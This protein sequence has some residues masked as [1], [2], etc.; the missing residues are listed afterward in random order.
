MVWKTYALAETQRGLVLRDG[1]VVEWLEPGRHRRLDP[2]N[3]LSL[4]I[5]EVGQ[6][7]IV[8]STARRLERLHPEMLKGRAVIIR[9][10]AH[11]LAL[12]SVDGM[13]YAVVPHT[14]MKALWTLMHDVEVEIIDLNTADSI[15]PK[16]AARWAPLAGRAIV[17][18]VIAEGETGLLMVDDQ[19]V[20]RLPPG[21][22][23]YWAADRT[24]RIVPQDL[25]PRT[26][27]V[28]A[29]E[30]LTEDRVTLRINVTAMLQVTDPERLVQRVAALDP[31]V[32]RQIQLAV[33]DAVGGRTLDA[34]LKARQEV[35]AGLTRT[36]ADRLG[37]IGVEIADVRIKDVILPGDMREM[38][39]RVVEAEKAAEANLI[40][41][42]EETAAT[43]ALL[44][45]ARLMENHPALMRLKELEALER[46]T[47]KVGRI[48]VHQTAQGAGLPAL[49][50]T[51]MG[52]RKEDDRPAL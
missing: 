8:T 41:R 24:V 1:C 44:N 29:Q 51:L 3:R 20:R 7:I 22:H 37:D 36:V 2:A 15:A 38:L 11:E 5:L 25:R 12:V 27:E 9:P 33:R 18:A 32:H 46:L 17:Q 21:R 10:A 49:I 42:R 50:D 23:A 43:R 26:L 13:P 35:D 4:E 47:D 30:I 40:R 52:A 28:V 16:E 48:D 31:L 6:P 34:L 39:N 14:Q 19:L 45:T